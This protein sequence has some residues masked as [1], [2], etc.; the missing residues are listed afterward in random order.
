[1]EKRRVRLVL[2]VVF[3]ALILFAGSYTANVALA[4][5]GNGGP[6]GA[7]PPI[8]VGGG[9]V[10]FSWS[11]C[12]QPVDDQGAFTFTSSGVAALKVTDAFI[13]GDRFRVY[14]GGTAIG[15]TSVPVDDGATIGSNADGAFASTKWSHGTFL[16]A[17]GSHSITIQTIAYATGFC[18]GGAYLRADP[19]PA[20]PSE[21]PEADTLLLMGGGVG[22]LATWVGWQWR[23]V[24][25][26]G[27]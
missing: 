3:L 25:A 24:R 8:T 7:R 23:R 4:G 12:G 17:P 5:G 22:G 10:P 26:R 18:S 16:L 11:H 14:D 19:G 20:L 1:M 15:D 2:V 9:W 27:K 21:V 6:S 13:D